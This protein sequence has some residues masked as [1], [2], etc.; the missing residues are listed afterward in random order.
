MRWWEESVW[1]Q[2]LPSSKC[3]QRN[4]YSVPFCTGSL[5]LA[6]PFILPD[7][8]AGLNLICRPLCPLGLLW[9]RCALASASLRTALCLD[10]LPPGER[11]ALPFSNAHKVTIPS[12]HTSSLPGC[13]PFISV[14]WA[15]HDTF[16]IEIISEF[17]KW[18][19]SSFSPPRSWIRMLQ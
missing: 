18:A 19:A 11:T 16:Q 7:C 8:L 1:C 9:H 2:V 10:S 17:Q 12:R 4:C 13:L 5:N 6:F 3:P 14:A 15:V